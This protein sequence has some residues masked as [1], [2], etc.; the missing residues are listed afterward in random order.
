LGFVSKKGYLSIFSSKVSF[1]SSE[2]LLSNDDETCL[3]ISSFGYSNEQNLWYLKNRYFEE[4]H[5]VFQVTCVDICKYYKCVFQKVVVSIGF[6][7]THML[8]Y[9][10]FANLHSHAK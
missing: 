1:E 9:E 8:G 7:S 6:I 2:S 3:C 4:I 10:H 5:V